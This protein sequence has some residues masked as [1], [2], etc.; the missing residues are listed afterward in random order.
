[1]PTLVSTRLNLVSVVDTFRVAATNQHSGLTY[2]FRAHGDVTARIKMD[3]ICTVEF[4]PQHGEAPRLVAGTVDTDGYGAERRVGSGRTLQELVHN[5][6]WPHRPSELAE[7]KSLLATRQ[8]TNCKDL[9]GDNVS[10]E[11][12][13]VQ[14]LRTGE[15]I[16]YC[17]EQLGLDS[18]IYQASALGYRASSEPKMLFAN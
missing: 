2:I 13:H 7:L 14:T 10:A 5:M 3:F 12:S 4:K 15:K 8:F 6:D 16:V 11:L 1:M 17:A 9:I 18:G